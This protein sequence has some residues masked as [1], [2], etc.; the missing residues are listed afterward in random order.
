M[1]DGGRQPLP[2]GGCEATLA[3]KQMA[4]CPAYEFFASTGISRN[5]SRYPRG[6][7][8]VPGEIARLREQAFWNAAGHA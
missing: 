2:W 4:K 6:K 5:E 7:E 8:G 3:Q 1:P